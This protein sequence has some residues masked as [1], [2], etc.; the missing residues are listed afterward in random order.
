MAA[1]IYVFLFSGVSYAL[2]NEILEIPQMIALLMTDMV[3]T[4]SLQWVVANASL[5]VGSIRVGTGLNTVL[6]H[7]FFGVLTEVAVTE[8]S[9][10]Q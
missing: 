10:E 7:C 2:P 4:H 9:T 6:V 5:E 1:R 3:V 8:G